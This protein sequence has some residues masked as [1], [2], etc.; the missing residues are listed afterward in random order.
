MCNIIRSAALTMAF[1]IAAASS[2]Q[3]QSPSDLSAQ[4]EHWWSDLAKDEPEASHA[5]LN[6]YDHADEVVPFLK[7]N[8]QP[9]RLN[10]EELDALLEQLGNEDETVWKP[11]WE[12][13]DYLDPRLA[14]DLEPL[15]EK[16]TESPQRQRITELMSGRDP[17]ALKGEAITLGKHQ[18]DD[19]TT[20]FNF[21]SKGSWWAEDKIE[22]LN[23]RYGNP[24]RQWT[25]ACRAIT[26]LEQIDTPEALEIIQAMGAGGHEDAQP[27]KVA[28]AAALRMMHRDPSNK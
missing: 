11:A 21:R 5:L 4:I 3:E 8:L 6:L 18:S 2:G 20:F 26:M 13:L 1:F 23:S 17:D 16:V 15:M 25:R 9:V 10:A 22:R 19:G 14:V 7:E 24:K 27:T 28:R 12:Q